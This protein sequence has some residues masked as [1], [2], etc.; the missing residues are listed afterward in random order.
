MIDHGHQKG[1]KINAW[2][3]QPPSR[4][5]INSGNSRLPSN[6]HRICNAEQDE[7]I[8][9]V[10]ESTTAIYIIDHEDIDIILGCDVILKL[11]PYI[12]I[13]NLRLQ[14]A[15]AHMTNDVQ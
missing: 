14:T 11:R 3:D 15:A 9:I 5:E 10:T 2:V 7:L 13:N 12:P 6:I 4:K 1:D 8:M